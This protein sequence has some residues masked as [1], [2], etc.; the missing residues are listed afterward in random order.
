VRQIPLWGAKSELG[1]LGALRS[2]QLVE[3]ADDKTCWELFAI[4]VKFVEVED[5]IYFIWYVFPDSPPGQ[6]DPHRLERIRFLVQFLDDATAKVYE[7]G[8]KAVIRDYA[9]SRLAGLLGFSIKRGAEGG[10]YRPVHPD[11]G[12]LMRLPFR[13]LVRQTAAKELAAAK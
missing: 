9:A 13:E 3:A 10:T 5:R 6:K 2:L 1:E 11:L 8:D 4:G 12:P 7:N